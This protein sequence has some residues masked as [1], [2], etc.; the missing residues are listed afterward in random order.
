MALQLAKLTRPDAGSAIVRERLFKKLDTARNYPLIWINAP[1]GAGKTTLIASYVESR[2][3]RHLWYQ[4]DAGD[5]DTAS[6]F[7]YLGKTPGMGGRRRKMP[8]L[9]PEYRQG[10]PQF[11]RHY[12]RELFQRLDEPA[13]LVLDNFQDVGDAEISA[14]LALACEEIPPKSSLVIVSRAASPASFARLHANRQVAEIHWHDLRFSVDEQLAI[15]RQRYPRHRISRQQMQDLDRH[16]HG[17]VTGLVLLL[18]Q[19]EEGIQDFDFDG[20]DPGQ[21]HLFD[22]F[23]RE[24]FAAIEEST[25][26]FLLQT[27]IL[28]KMNAAICRELTG[29]RQA[30]KILAEL[31]RRQY[32]TVRRGKLKPGYEYHPLFRQFL[33]QQAGEQLGEEAYQQLQSRAGLLMAD[34]GG[35][36]DAAKL[37]IAAQNWPALSELVLQHAHQQIENGRNQQVACWIEQLPDE[38]MQQQP[39]LLYWLG[40]GY[41]RYE[42]QRARKW[43]ECAYAQFK[44]EKNAKGLYLSW[45]GVSDAYRFAHD[46]FMGADRWIEELDWLQK[47][48]SR[49]LDLQLRGH[50]VFSATGLLLWAQP[51]HPDLPTWIN[52]LE[53]LYRRVPDASLKVMCAGQ[54]CIYYSHTGEIEKL[55]QT[56]RRLSKLEEKNNNSA[57]VRSVIMALKCSIDWL[58]G[59]LKIQD[60]QIDEQQQFIREQGIKVY[61]GL[62]L[63]QSLYHATCRRDPDRVE[64]LLESYADDVSD[65]DILGQ[66]Y[67]Q[68]HSCNLQI[69][70][71][72]HDLALTHGDLALELAEQSAVPFA[73]WFA[74]ALVAWLL[75]EKEDY[76]QARYYLGVVRKIVEPMRSLSGIAVADMLDSYLAWRRHDMATALM[77]LASGFQLARE[78]DVKASGVWPPKMISTLC[79]LALD[80]NIE[81]DYARKLICIYHYTPRDAAYQ[82]ECWPW[83]LKIFTLGRFS[84]LLNDHPLEPGTRTLALLK[85]ILANGGRD[86]PE[87]RIIDLLWPDVDGDQGLSRFKIT[88]HRLRKLLGGADRLLL[89]NHQLSLNQQYVWV[90]TWCMSRL[91]AEIENLN[92]HK[93]TAKAAHLL[94]RLLQIYR[95]DFLASDPDE[96]ILQHRESLRNRFIRYLL[97]LARQ[98]E[99]QDVQLSLQAY[100]R[101]LEIHS[102]LEEAWQGMLR[103]YLAQDRRAE[104]RACYN[105]CVAVLAAANGSQPST[106]TTALIE[107]H[108]SSAAS[109]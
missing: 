26:Q 73:R 53:V 97:I 101:L 42:N 69:L 45:C 68:L 79:G 75:T 32:F 95:G 3:C 5:R 99:E 47:T 28:P 18:E 94:H 82:A 71:G 22:Y 21:Q 2:N 103:V 90:D 62:S 108:S 85:V 4:M 44:K 98:L 49:P 36:D 31:A 9:S 61:S 63:S 106:A 89:K 66:C 87:A 72:N 41:L 67:F 15:A 35:V 54:L 105:K 80:H 33:L 58:T 25:R 65:N 55:R 43:F 83:P 84:I 104:A 29:N 78:K 109:S 86:M 8:A 23:A 91:F 1:A 24:I 81:P 64:A 107:Q 51:G 50:L 19:G 7:H 48:Y 38:I 77:R 59:E 93:D 14:L 52:R 17:W 34:A 37:L 56:G 57:L 92:G 20:E 27:A 16:L 70:R 102:L 100:Q 96:W 12:F 76:E 46:H 39:W 88:L 40:M 74:S 11:T 60:A 6:F 13:L 30:G 10:L